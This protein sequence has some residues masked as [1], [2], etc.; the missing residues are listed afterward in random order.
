[1][2]LPDGLD[3]RWFAE[4]D[5]PTKFLFKLKITDEP[6]LLSLEMAMGIQAGVSTQETPKVD[7]MDLA[8][9]EDFDGLFYMDP[10]YPSKS[11]HDYDYSKSLRPMFSPRVLQ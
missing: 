6:L 7:I 3:P 2:V 8:C 4:T 5:D 10:F 9:G 1:M 11:N